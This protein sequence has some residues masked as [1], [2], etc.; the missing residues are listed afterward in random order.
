MSE[1]EISLKGLFDIQNIYSNEELFLNLISDI[2]E[3][4]EE[5]GILRGRPT[6]HLKTAK[7]LFRVYEKNPQVI[8]CL[9][10]RCRDIKNC[11]DVKKGILKEENKFKPFI[12][13]FH[14]LKEMREKRKASFGLA[15][16]S[17]RVGKLSELEQD[18][19]ISALNNFNLDSRKTQIKEI[20][21]KLEDNDLIK[22]L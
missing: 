6:K 19:T 12:C 2:V 10:Q 8:F 17:L 11:F 1:E 3:G 14:K 13:T 4:K 16:K 15:E 5:I 22:L 20:V 7:Q 18:I 21:M 9:M